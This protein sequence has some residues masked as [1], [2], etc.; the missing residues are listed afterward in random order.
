MSLAKKGDRFQ[1]QS[2]FSANRTQRVLT[3]LTNRV[4]VNEN[5]SPLTSSGIRESII[6]TGTL[7]KNGFTTNYRGNW[8][9]SPNGSRQSTQTLRPMLVIMARQS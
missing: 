8:N 4:G 2:E 9:P 5:S 6:N 7:A 1:I 3:G